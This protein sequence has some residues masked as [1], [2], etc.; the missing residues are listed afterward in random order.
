MVS[1]TVCHVPSPSAFGNP[2]ASKGEHVRLY[3]AERFHEY[4]DTRLGRGS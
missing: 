3:L 2:D 1:D 4:A